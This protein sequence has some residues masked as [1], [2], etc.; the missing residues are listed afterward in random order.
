ME[1]KS[2]LS[3]HVALCLLSLTIAIAAAS[4][5]QAAE[6]KWIKLQSARFGVLSQLS[7]EDTRAWAVQFDQFIDA[8][9]QLYSVNDVALP[10]LTIVMFKQAKDFAPFQI[11]TASGQVKVDGFFATQSGWSVIG[12]TGQGSDVTRH[13]IQHEAVHWF[14]SASTTPSPLWFSEG[15]AEVL[16]TFEAKQGKGRWGRAIPSHAEYLSYRGLV[17]LEQFL[18]KSQDEA[19]HG[20]AADTY[21]PEAWAFVHYL[22]FGNNGAQR[23]KLDTL[24]KQLRDNDLDTAFN[25][26][27]GVSYDDVTN[28]LRK[29]LERGRYAMALFDLRPQSSDMTVEPASAA[30]VAFALARLA[31]GSD[32]YDI[33][34]PYVQQV[35]AAAPDAPQGYELTA[36]LAEHAKDTVAEKTAVDRAIQLGSRESRMYSLRAEL[37]FANADTNLAWD[38]FM[39]RTVARAAADDLERSL[40]LLPRNRTAFQNLAVALLNVDTVTDVDRSALA[41]GLRMF[42]NEGMILVGQA[43]AEK[44]AGN[45]VE[46]GGLLYKANLEPFAL[47]ARFRPSV[48]ALRNNWVGTWYVEHFARLAADGEFSEA[49]QFVEEQLADATITGRLHS[50]LEGI[51]QDLPHLE[52][53]YAADEALRKGRVSVARDLLVSITTSNVSDRVRHEAERRLEI[54]SRR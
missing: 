36:L 50:M 44:S 37:A 40:T 33:A 48:T 51:Q 45:I 5:S 10:P 43:A 53:M 34:E 29:Y 49:R 14:A 18:R 16:A 39:S 21:Y 15:I 27:F 17:P 2:R 11:R 46:A 8:M 22:L 28:D 3:T 20:P 19:L 6:P 54:L 13:V 31:I 24:L 38:D 4:T 52:R 42:P 23:G 25:A 12:L 7:A 1:A 26:A 35:L 32:N 30:N 47:S 9:H 41:A